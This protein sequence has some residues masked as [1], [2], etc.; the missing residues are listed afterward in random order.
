MNKMDLLERVIKEA[1]RLYTVVP[2]IARMTQKEI[3]LCKEIYF[4]LLSHLLSLIGICLFLR[5]IVK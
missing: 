2:I 3:K 1:M 4:S 5:H